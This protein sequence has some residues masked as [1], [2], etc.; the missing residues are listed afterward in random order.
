[1]TTPPKHVNIEG[2]NTHLD[3]VMC[4]GLT[5]DRAVVFSTSS[6]SNPLQS[7]QAARHIGTNSKTYRNYQDLSEVRSERKGNPCR[8]YQI[9]LS[10]RSKSRT[11]QTTKNSQCRRQ[12]DNIG[13]KRRF[14]LVNWRSD[15]QISTFHHSLVADHRMMSSTVAPMDDT[16]ICATGE[17]IALRR[18]A[19]NYSECGRE[20]SPRRGIASI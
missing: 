11:A 6:V 12:P 7:A 8:R 19:T 15:V 9:R 2:L 20:I 5:S 16:K 17:E 18:N 13:E 1:M 14:A 3:R 4:N 10:P